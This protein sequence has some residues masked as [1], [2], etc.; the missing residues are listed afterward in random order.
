VYSVEW[1]QDAVGQL[2]AL[3][4]EALPFFA[5]LVTVLQVEPWSG[6][7]YNRQRA[8]ANMRTH[9]VGH[10]GEAWSSISSLTISGVSSSCVSSGPARGLRPRDGGACR[11]NPRN[12]AYKLVKRGEFP[13]TVLRP[14][15][16]YR[17]P[18]TGL[19]KALEIE[20]VPVYLDDADRGAAFAGQFG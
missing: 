17:V 20:Q 16:R 10:H 19:M 15:Y 11:R 5:E 7:A 14:G 12:T 4:S 2:A 9:A 1:E 6:D 18:A 3:P 8:D 13:C